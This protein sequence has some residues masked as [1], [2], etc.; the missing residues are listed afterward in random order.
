VVAVAAAAVGVAGEVVSRALFQNP[1][2]IGLVAGGGLIC[3]CKSGCAG[4]SSILS[5][6]L[7]VYDEKPAGRCIFSSS[8]IEGIGGGEYGGCV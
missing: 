1:S 3:S 6:S 2:S 4:N 5:I 7:E 8:Y